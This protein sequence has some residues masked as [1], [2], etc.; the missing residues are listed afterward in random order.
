MAQQNDINK[1]TRKEIT[2]VPH[3]ESWD[4]DVHCDSLIIVPAEIQ[5]KSVQKY[6]VRL[7]TSRIFSW[8][9]R[10]DLWDIEGMHDSG[11]RCM[12]FVA[13]KNNKP[14]CRISGCSDVIHIDGIGGYGHR[15]YS[16]YSGVPKMVP[17]TDWN[18]DCLAESGLLRMF[19][20][21][22]NILCGASLSSFEIYATDPPTTPEPE[23]E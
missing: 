8:V 13:V 10:P 6:R 12:T 3:R 23:G 20:G 15:W 2:A 16:K 18:I 11:Y 19:N 9:K 17:P 1:M 5:R 14:I 21:E 4:T 7:L 22:R